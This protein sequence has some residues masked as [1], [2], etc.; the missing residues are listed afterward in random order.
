MIKP[1]ALPKTNWKY[2]NSL[3]AGLPTSPGTDI[4]VTP[5]NAVPIIPKATRYHLEF[6]FAVKKVEL[7]ED[8]LEVKY[9]TPIS[10]RKY[11]TRKLSSIDGSMFEFK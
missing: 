5:D 9:D 4:K 2:L 3:P 6:L 10:M 8:F 11:A 7:S 1:I